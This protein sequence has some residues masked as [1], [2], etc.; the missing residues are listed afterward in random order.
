MS[1]FKDVS[2]GSILNIFYLKNNLLVK[3]GKAVE[4]KQEGTE[5]PKALDEELHHFKQDQYR[6]RP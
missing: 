5:H 2:S 3:F 6:N 4:N 1:T